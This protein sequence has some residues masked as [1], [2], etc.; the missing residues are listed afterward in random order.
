MHI[1]D[2]ITEY[3]QAHG[4]SFRQYALKCGVTNGYIS[5]LINGANPKTGKPLRP[6]VETYA[7]L[8][9]GMGISVNDLFEIMDDAPVSLAVT[10][11]QPMKSPSS[12]IPDPVESELVSIY[13]DLNSTGKTILV[14]TARGLSA[15]HDMKKGSESNTET[16]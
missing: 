12:I 9:A 7:K 13:R 4:L 8:A 6:T 16:A 10:G 14:N 15:N 11:A 3:C 1:G 5:M 2:I